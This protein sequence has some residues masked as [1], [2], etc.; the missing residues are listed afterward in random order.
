MEKLGVVG[1][2]AVGAE[3]NLH[4]WP[5]FEVGCIDFVSD[6]IAFF[7]TCTYPPLDPQ[8]APLTNFLVGQFETIQRRL[9]WPLH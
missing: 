8:S 9:A 3:P 1:G 7:G 4:G 6:I 2:P 5:G